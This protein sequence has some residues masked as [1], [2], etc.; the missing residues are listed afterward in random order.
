MGDSPSPARQGGQLGSRS[1][2]YGD[3]R[4]TPLLGRSGS[5]TAGDMM[6]TDFATPHPG[7]KAFRVVR[8]RLRG[9]AEAVGFLVVD[10]VQR[11]TGMKLVPGTGFVGV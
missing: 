10:P 11:I 4:A 8:V 7:E 2:P 1:A 9:V 5:G 3:P 6:M